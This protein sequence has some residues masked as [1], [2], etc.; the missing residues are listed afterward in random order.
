MKY[1]AEL[2]SLKN[3]LYALIVNVSSVYVDDLFIKHETLLN[4][5]II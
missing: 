2:P 3:E 4:T 1:T 5:I